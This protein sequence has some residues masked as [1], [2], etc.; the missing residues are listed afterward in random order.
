MVNIRDQRQNEAVQAYLNSERKSLVKA[1]PRFGK[2]RV[3][4]KIIDKL[5][6]QN[7]I[8]VA[9]RQEIFTSWTNEFKIIGQT[10]PGVQFV[11]F[12]SLHKV[13]SQVGD[14]WI[15]DEPNEMSQ[16][17]LQSLKKICQNNKNVLCLSG[18]VTKKTED[19]LLAHGGIT[20]C[21][22]YSI[23]Q[24]V[25]ENVLSDYRIFVHRVKLDD[26]EL[27]YK[28]KSGKRISERTRFSNYLYVRDKLKDEGQDYFFMELKLIKMLQD[29]TAKFNKTKELLEQFKYKRCLVF[30]GLTEVADRLGIPVYHSKAK[31][32]EIFKDFCEG[33]NYD[34]LACIK[35]IQSGI[36]VKPID[37][38]IMNYLSGAPED[39]CQKIC[40]M[41]GFEYNTPNKV[42]Q[43]HIVS[44]TEGF[45]LERLESALMFFDKEKIQYL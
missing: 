14:L 13:D 2:C 29:S 28:N 32:K 15:I 6:A 16:R 35:L 12:T 8:I 39:T 3:G 1:A 40:R 27:Q 11:T 44:T 21:F 36:T 31:E 9:P 10:F 4:I 20:T 5:M 30:C 19:K 7:I 34:H 43:I 18:T 26:Q 23:S 25:A 38:G 41:F 45:E 42:A 37:H 22:T 33:R 24:A 17:N